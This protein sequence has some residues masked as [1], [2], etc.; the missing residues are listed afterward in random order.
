MAK[1]MQTLAKALVVTADAC[2]FAS[3]ISEEGKSDG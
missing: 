2:G 1:Q 3:L